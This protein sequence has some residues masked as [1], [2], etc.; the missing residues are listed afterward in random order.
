MIIKNQNHKEVSYWTL[1]ILIC[2]IVIT[3]IINFPTNILS[4]DTFGYYLYLPQLFIYNDLGIN[5]IGH[6][7]SIVDTY[8]NTGTL[9]QIW[10]TETGNQLIRYTSGQAVMFAPFFLIAHLFTLATGGVADGFSLPYQIAIFAGCMCYF[11]IAMYILRRI[12]RHFFSDKVTAVTLGLLLIGTNLLANTLF[13]IACIHAQLF[14]LYTILIYYTIQWHQNPSWKN[15]I[16]LAIASGLIILTRP[17]DIICLLIPFMWNIFDISSFKDKVR[18]CLQKYPQIIASAIIAIIGSIQIIYWKVF[19]NHFILDSYNNPGEGMEFFHPYIK[20]TLF[21]FRK[22]WF[23]YTP[24]MFIALIGLIP[25]FK[26]GKECFVPCLLFVICNIYLVSCWSCWWYAGSFGQR[27]YIQSYA[28][29]SLPLGFFIQYVLDRN[30][31]IKPLILTILGLFCGLNIFQTWQYHQRIISASRMTREAYF[32]NFFRIDKNTCDESLLLIHRDASG[33]EVMDSTRNYT[34]HWVKTQLYDGEGFMIAP[35]IEFSPAV[36]IPY[37]QITT[38]DHAWM[39]IVFWVKPLEEIT[40]NAGYFTVT[41]QHKGGNYKYRSMP[42]SSQLKIGEWNK[43][44]INYLTPE[45][46]DD[47]DVLSIYYWNT[48]NSHL[49]IKKIDIYASEEQ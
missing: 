20:E 23:V 30:N 19:A 3:A 34:E 9:Y 17:T 39:R 43:V 42:L 49:L 12:L 11:I 32:S 41:F 10:E 31:R 22:G 2:L 48:G 38:N 8:H 35:T 13:G 7:Q 46:R 18:L 4:W 36:Q 26:R 33:I 1:L 14:F 16:P 44:E 37:H 28:L 45:V 21:S 15:I 47:N 5:D 25:A 24:L 27:A 29:M 6:L 40:E